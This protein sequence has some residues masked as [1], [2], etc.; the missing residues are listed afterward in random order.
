MQRSTALTRPLGQPAAFVEAMT[1]VRGSRLR[2]GA[3]YRDGEQDDTFVEL[4]VVPSWEEHLRQHD[5]RLTGTDR[6]Y[7]QR[8]TALAEGEPVVARLVG[9]DVP[10]GA[11]T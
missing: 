1:R 9:V 3:L 2:T 4:F 7:Q 5:E 8:A 10:P 11:E 6:A